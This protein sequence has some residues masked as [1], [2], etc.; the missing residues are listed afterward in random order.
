[1]LCPNTGSA[2]GE[3]GAV[4]IVCG[5]NGNTAGSFLQG[6]RPQ[7]ELGTFPSR[8]CGA[9]TASSRN[10]QL[11]QNKRPYGLQS[12]G[13]ATQWISRL[14]AYQ[15]WGTAACGRQSWQQPPFAAG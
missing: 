3:T 8:I 12:L 13:S 15:F 14:S 11:E 7:S 2:Q 9:G 4:R 5:R 6:R 1:M 10:S